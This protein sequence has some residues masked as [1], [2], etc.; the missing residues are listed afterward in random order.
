MGYYGWGMHS[1]IIGSWIVGVLFWIAIGIIFVLL[2][3]K[4]FTRNSESVTTNENKEPGIKANTET[5]LDILK[6]RYAKGE[7]ML[8]EFEKIKKDIQ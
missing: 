3:A 6:K 1:S 7:I 5:A 8:K 4:I 2:L